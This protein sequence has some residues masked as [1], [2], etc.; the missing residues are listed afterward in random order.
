MAKKISTSRLVSDLQNLKKEAKQNNT[1]RDRLISVFGELINDTKFRGSPIEKFN[2]LDAGTRNM[3]Y[4]NKKLMEKVLGDMFK[5]SNKGNKQEHPQ[6]INKFLKNLQYDLEKT[7]YNLINYPENDEVLDEIIKEFEDNRSNLTKETKELLEKTKKL[8]EYQKVQRELK[9]NN[10]YYRKPENTTKQQQEEQ[11][12]QTPTL[13]SFIDSAESRKD[14]E[15]VDKLIKD[16]KFE[17]F[18]DLMS[19]T[20][21]YINKRKEITAEDNIQQDEFI[22][23]YMNSLTTK[24]LERFINNAVVGDNE[25]LSEEQNQFFKF[26]NDT[27]TNKISET[28]RLQLVV[29]LIENPKVYN[30][31]K[32]DNIYP[33]ILSL[34]EKYRDE[35]LVNYEDRTVLEEMALSGNKDSITKLEEKIK[36]G[37]ELSGS[38]KQMLI[39]Y[40]GKQGYTSKISKDKREYKKKLDTQEEAIKKEI[41]ENEKKIKII[42]K[43]IKELEKKIAKNEELLRKKQ[44]EL[45]EK[46]NKNKAG[47]FGKQNFGENRQKLIEEIN[48][49]KIEIEQDKKN[50]S[51]QQQRKNVLQTNTV[52]QK[53]RIQQINKYRDKNNRGGL[54]G[55]YKLNSEIENFKQLAQGKTISDIIE[56]LNDSDDKD[57]IN[58]AIL[59]SY[60][61]NAYEL[62]NEDF[63]KLVDYCIEINNSSLPA[64]DNVKKPLDVLLEKDS[65]K[66]FSNDRVY[67]LLHNEKLKNKTQNILNNLPDNKLSALISKAVEQ[68]EDNTEIEEKEKEKVVKAKLRN[69][70]IINTLNDAQKINT[71][72]K[73]GKFESLNTLI[74]Y[75]KDGFNKKDPE[76]NGNDKNV[77]MNSIV[78]GLSLEKTD[79]IKTPEEIDKQK[80]INKQTIQTLKNI[81]EIYEDNEYKD[82]QDEIIEKI[83]DSIE[84]LVD[85]PEVLEDLIDFV[86]SLYDEE[87]E[88]KKEQKNKILDKISFFGSESIVLYIQNNDI[89]DNLL[90][91]LIEKN[92]DL[93]N[94]IQVNDKNDKIV[95]QIGRILD[96]SDIKVKQDIKD[97]LAEFKEKYNKSKEDSYKQKTN[98]IK[99]QENSINNQVSQTG[100]QKN[101]QTKEK[102]KQQ[103]K[104]KQQ[105]VFSAFCKN[106]TKFMKEC[107][108]NPM[109][110][111]ELMMFMNSFQNYQG[112]TIDLEKMAEYY[113]EPEKFMKEF[114][115]NPM[116]FAGSFQQNP[117]GSQQCFQNYVQMMGNFPPSLTNMLCGQALPLQQQCAM[118]SYPA[119]GIPYPMVSYPGNIV[120]PSTLLSATVTQ[121]RYEQECLSELRKQNKIAQE[122]LELKRQEVEELKR[123]NDIKENKQ[124]IKLL[125]DIKGEDIRNDDKIEVVVYSGPNRGVKQNITFVRK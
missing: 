50:I 5:I 25:K 101:P 17:N 67:S 112:E 21:K 18:G 118:M 23:S 120:L 48:I 63:N 9:R 96:N 56:I 11:K 42:D 90:L 72:Q 47:L 53:N 8:I 12:S 84:N 116:K 111:V 75:A 57:L 43:N 15:Q 49:L 73:D 44:K 91:E 30:I 85:T 61:K 37:E 92:S 103:D 58:I 33:N 119:M 28:V 34:I 100:E 22:V 31:I 71:L 4:H 83:I 88:D 41:K 102:N 29:S 65:L 68:I 87:K 114:M 13:D 121:M 35:K 95:A 89:C 122:K 78:F 24:D 79:K 66:N 104:Q 39:L 36:N 115:E 14:I 46:Y 3:I 19:V 38:M 77:M 6:E 2:T 54:E 113:K 99:S 106:P 97:K 76:K 60:C 93:L 40:S 45:Y 1:S 62:E 82:G 51:A 105:N 86:D 7:K 124:I 94:E 70:E 98:E 52:G 69:L 55:L 74:N 81:Y 32:N 117:E 80:K 10:L 20:D 26:I 59:N 125:S 109:K 16:V 123:S 108:E 107:T 64:D 27:Q 110:L